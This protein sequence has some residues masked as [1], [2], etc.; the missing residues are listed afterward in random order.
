M[1]R[2]LLPL[3]AALALPISSSAYYYNKQDLM[4]DEIK[5][6][7]LILSSN[8]VDN[9]I[10]IEQEA[11]I[12][13]KCTTKDNVMTGLEAGISTPSYNADSRMLRLRWDKETPTRDSW[14]K[15]SNGKGFFSPSPKSFIT[16]LNK[17]DTLIA[18]WSPYQKAPVAAK[19]NLNELKKDIEKLTEV[20]CGSFK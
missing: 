4:T 18:E 15:A 20:G 2:L 12:F 11:S 17:F 9:V 6:S 7:V 10:G 8:K 13:I 3:L 5:H 19:F 1:K 16:E 14:Q